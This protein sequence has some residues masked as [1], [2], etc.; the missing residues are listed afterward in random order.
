MMNPQGLIKHD[1]ILIATVL[2]CSYSIKPLMIVDLINASSNGS[3]KK[4]PTALNN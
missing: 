3:L 2:N 1:V 4:S